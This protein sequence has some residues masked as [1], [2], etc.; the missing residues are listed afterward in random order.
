MR[1]QSRPHDSGRVRCDGLDSNSPPLRDGGAPEDSRWDRGVSEYT[2]CKVE[3][4]LDRSSKSLYHETYGP[5]HSV[6]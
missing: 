6:P 5:D 3:H 1:L 4:E 2:E